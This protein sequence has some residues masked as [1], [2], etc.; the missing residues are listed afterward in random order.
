MDIRQLG[1]KI[2]LACIGVGVVVEVPIFR[3]ACQECVRPGV[4]QSRRIHIT[5]IEGIFIHILFVFR[6]KP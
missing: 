1:S 6:I 2:N 5:R 3:P 4:H